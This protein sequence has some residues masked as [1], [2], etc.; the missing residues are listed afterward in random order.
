MEAPAGKEAKPNIL[1]RLGVGP[2]SRVGNHFIEEVGSPEAHT[3]SPNLYGK[4]KAPALQPRPS[5][6]FETLFA[7]SN[8]TTTSTP[9]S[10]QGQPSAARYIPPAARY[11]PAAPR[12]DYGKAMGELR[13]THADTYREVGRA[14]IEADQWPQIEEDR[15]ELLQVGEEEDLSRLPLMEEEGGDELSHLVAPIKIS[16][17]DLQEEVRPVVAAL[18]E[19][20]VE[21]ALPLEE[22]EI[23][24]Y[25]GRW[26]RLPHWSPYCVPE[27]PVT[28]RDQIREA[29]IP[30]AGHES[31]SP[32]AYVGHRIMWTRMLVDTD[33]SG[34]QEVHY[35]MEKAPVSWG[36]ILIL[37]NIT[38]TM[39]LYSK[40]VE[41][42]A[43]LV[44]AA[45]SEYAGAKTITID[46]LVATLKTMGFTPD[47]PQAIPRQAHFDE[48]GR[49]ESAPVEDTGGLTGHLEAQA[50]GRVEDEV[51]KQVYAALQA[52]Q[53]SPPPGGYPFP[54]NDQETIVPARKT[55]DREGSQPMATTS[56]PSG[57][58]NT[59]KRKFVLDNNGER[60]GVIVEEVEDEDAFAS[61]RSKPKAAH[62]ILEP[63]EDEAETLAAGDPTAK[64]TRSERARYEDAEQ[65]WR[66]EGRIFEPLESGSCGDEDWEGEEKDAE[67]NPPE[68]KYGV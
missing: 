12:P 68:P 51:F 46:N 32:C 4:S 55:A 1:K 49:V 34:P 11:G 62:S 41:H 25:L 24:G 7:T 14:P 43:A 17:L 19:E 15:K 10:N 53:H 54:K 3:T 40:V 2:M 29:A 18:R 13:T 64:G 59:G 37:E 5:N 50:V 36:P 9:A 45:C 56:L 67:L 58:E 16:R 60:R 22:G 6:P 28:T 66:N 65:F 20:E 27:Y 61:W 63:M 8:P 57:P 44:N 26:G 47:R 42:E 30:T 39:S 31:E 35:V 21:E 23:H 52:K 33:D 48:G 38:S